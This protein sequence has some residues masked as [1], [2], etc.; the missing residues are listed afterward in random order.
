[1]RITLMALSI[2]LV[3]HAIAIAVEPGKPTNRSGDDDTNPHLVLPCQPGDFKLK[4]RTHIGDRAVE[5]AYLLHLPADYG[6]ELGKTYPMLVFFHGIGE[7]GT[8]LAGVSIY[9]PMTMIAQNP[10]FAA[11]FPFIVLCP[12]CPPDA[13]WDTDYMYKSAAKLVAQTIRNTRTDPDRVYAT[14]LSMGGLGAWCVAEE[15]PDLFAAIAPLSAMAWHPEQAADRLRY[16]YVWAISGVNDQPRFIEGARAMD[17][18]LAH[19]PLPVRFTYFVDK[20]HE[21]WYPPFQNVGF[22][23]WLLAHRRLSPA[24]RKKLDTTPAVPTSQPMP[25]APG[26]YF[27]SFQIKLG[28]QPLLMDYSLYLPK[29]YK[30][31]GPPRPVMLFLHEQ[32]TIGPVFHDLCVHGPDLELEKR[33]ALQ[34]NFPFIVISPRVPIDCDWNRPGITQ[35]LLDLID[36]VGQSV[37]I[38]A[39]RM[40]ISGINAGASGAWKIVTEAPERFSAIVPVFTAGPLTLPDNIDRIMKTIPGR[41]YVKS[42][43][44]TSVDRINHLIDTIKTDWKITPLPD[45][46]S[47][48]EE[49]PS[50]ADR[51]MLAWLAEQRR[52]NQP[53]SELTK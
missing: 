52:V 20:G 8:D 51:Q 1:M 16:V 6:K 32:D 45:S 24:Q 43:Q 11:S 7:R 5:M 19:D 44:L 29:G 47:V 3:F 25:T 9:G 15:A 38:D 28:N 13:T 53:V 36:H 31:D 50:Y 35:A 42:A 48:V 39:D 37:S 10:A 34:N 41:I 49:V 26:H 33:P 4:Y 23:E 2:A 21:A 14:G 17:A 27:L 22:Y 18:A 46:A 40:S 30:P 12:Q